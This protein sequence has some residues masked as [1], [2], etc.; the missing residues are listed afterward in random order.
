MK[1][2]YEYLDVIRGITLLSMIFYHGVWDLVYIADYSWE[3]FDSGF[4]YIW[5]QSICWTFILLS[6][7]CWS[8]GRSRLRRGLIIF[9]AGLLVSA[10]T[11]FFL[12]QQMVLFGV[13]TMLGS[14]MLIMIPLN[15]LLSAMPATGGLVFSI[16]L[17]VLT[18]NVNRGSLGFE[19]LS[20]LAL[21]ESWYDKG[22]LMTFV[23]FMDKD[24]CSTDY[25]SIIPWFF[26][27]TSG[28][29]LFRLI[30]NKGLLEKS[31]RTGFAK[32]PAFLTP[33]SF[34]GR[35]SLFIYLIHQPTIYVL[36]TLF[37]SD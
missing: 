4:A 28:Y 25:F 9:G 35:H 14:S 5:Q 12:P 21:P 1:Q 15:K 22:Y 18:R 32:I 23:G 26:L 34:M 17:F 30:N 33:L 20:I 6:G 8:M 7:F 10:A 3:W 37:Q 31:F 24:F 13:L 27:F 29:F 16:V 2:R 11:I 19:G 36:I